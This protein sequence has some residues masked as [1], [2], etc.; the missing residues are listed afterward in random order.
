MPYYEYDEIQAMI[1][2]RTREYQERIRQL[3]ARLA[4][5]ESVIMDKVKL[6]PPG[7]IVLQVTPDE[8]ARLTEGLR[9]AAD[10]D[11]SERDGE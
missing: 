4:W 2:A 6:M 1:S 9:I 3:E 5:A 8:A 7:P 10:G 11:G